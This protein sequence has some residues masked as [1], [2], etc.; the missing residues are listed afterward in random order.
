MAES[1]NDFGLVEGVGAEA[2]G[3]P[4]QRTFRLVARGSGRYAS[5][6]ME[7]EQLSALGTALQQQIVRLGRPALR[8][9]PAP[10]LGGGDVPAR[11]DVDFRCGQLGLGFDEGR[12]EFVV[13]AY[14][15]EAEEPETAAWSGR[16][17]LAQA[18]A[19]SR[20]IDAVVN[21]G[22]PKCPLCGAVMDE[23]VH[24]C[25]RANGHAKELS[26]G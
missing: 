5:L 17:S 10:L 12:S 8:E 23:P 20:E 21:A 18:R 13:F 9:R 25:P 16:L 19:L 3:Q 4:G 7:K 22:R 1:S 26:N 14:N 15:A 11:A 24:I 2:V 6:W